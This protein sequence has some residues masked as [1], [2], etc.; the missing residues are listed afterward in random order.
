ALPICQLDPELQ[1][2]HG[3]GRVQVQAAVL[4]INELAAVLP[5][6]ALKK[7]VVPAAGDG[8][9][10]PGHLPAFALGEKGGVLG[11]FVPRP[12]RPV[13]VEAN[14]GESLLVPVEDRRAALEGDGPDLAVV[15]AVFP[16][17][18]E[19]VVEVGGVLLGQ[20]LIQRDDGVHGQQ[21]WEFRDLHYCDVRRV[22]A[23]DR[24]LHLLHGRVVVAG[25][26]SDH[27][28]GGVL[29][30]TLVYHFVDDS[31]QW[32]RHADRVVK[33]EPDQLLREHGLGRDKTDQDDEQDDGPRA[34]GRRAKS[35]HYLH[36]P[37]FSFLMF[38]WA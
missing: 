2:F 38:V 30:V 10:P 32:A 19:E 8:D 1:G 16:E 12:R 25:V 33:G 23:H 14:L 37:R 24:R 22:A 26:D 4:K 27:F 7:P 9:A 28:D 5:Y 31:G 21:R 20:V 3:F 34:C 29:V 6:K 18:G 13:G 11:Q 17:S 15:T 36:L 35:P